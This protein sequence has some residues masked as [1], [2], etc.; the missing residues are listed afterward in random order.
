MH[1]DLNAMIAACRT[2]AKRYIAL[3]ERNGAKTIQE[4][5]EQVF[6][7]S[8]HM[9]RAKIAEIPDGSYSASVM[10]DH[11]GVEIEKPYK[12]AV[13]VNVDGDNMHIDWTGTADTV[14][15]PTNHPF[16][17]TV[18]IAQVVLKSLT[19]PHDPTNHGHM[20]P[21]SVTAPANSAV[22]PQYP[23]PTDS[24]GYVGEMI[25]HLIVKAL[26]QAIPER[27]P[28]AT[29]QMFGA[30]FYRMDP[31]H[32]EPF[33]YIDPLAG[34]GGAFPHA[35]GPNALIFVGDGNAPNTPT[36][37]IEGHYPLR[38]LRHTFNLE[39]AGEGKY[40]GGLGVIREFEM[41]EDN[42]L[43]QSMSENS[44]D[45]PWG[46]Y[47]GGDSGS[48]K[49]IAWQGTDREE[50]ITQRVYF[51]GPFQKGD[52]VSQRSAGGGGWGDPRERD[53]E[54]IEYDL[55]NGYVLPDLP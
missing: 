15:G 13:T 7:Q 37:V 33:I 18:A 22:S 54:L 45:T 41:L 50:E 27:C 10:M 17:G 20:R 30:V 52:I 16:V 44:I 12:L 48:S 26:S 11:D 4:A 23:A 8:E 32:G 19:M 21:L 5:M 34:G 42:I 47:G 9:M 51:F 2:G 25:I 55:R 43:M 3:C 6:D 39:G 36:E 53:P 1:G 40:R 29:Y 49:L 24:Y 28:A 14:T 31:R 46:L 38:V 35:D